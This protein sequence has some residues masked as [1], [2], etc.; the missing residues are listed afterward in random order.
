MLEIGVGLFLVARKG[1]KL[2]VSWNLF[3]LLAVESNRALEYKH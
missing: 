2:I 1:L 3:L